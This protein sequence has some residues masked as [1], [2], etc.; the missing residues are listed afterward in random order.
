MDT[1]LVL[2]VLVAVLVLV[3]AV[4]AVLLVV[5]LRGA[6][7]CNHLL[8]PYGSEFYYEARPNI[9]IAAPDPGSPS[10]ALRLDADWALAP[11]PDPAKARKVVEALAA[12]NHAIER[13]LGAPPNSIVLMKPELLEAWFGNSAKDPPADPG[14]A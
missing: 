11:Q 6:Y 3:L 4:V 13:L 14:E 1:T 2:A 10:A 12:Y 9:A 8:V 5:F 7:D